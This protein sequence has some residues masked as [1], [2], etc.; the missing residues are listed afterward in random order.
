MTQFPPP[1]GDPNAPQAYQPAP[2]Y[3]PPPPQG[4]APPAPGY[5]MAPPPA[6]GYGYGSAQLGPVGKLRSGV[7]VIFLSIITLGIYGLVYW[8]KT[9]DEMKKHADVG[10]GGAIYLILGLFVGI[11]N[12]FLLG[13][14][15]KTLRVNAGMEPKVSALTVFWALIPIVGAFIAAAKIQGALNEYW[16]SKGAVKA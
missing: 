14:D 16:I 12:P 4:Y 3:P 13:N 11:V 10:V 9:G 7:A 5:P 6:P 2:G 15:V 8:Y 1:A